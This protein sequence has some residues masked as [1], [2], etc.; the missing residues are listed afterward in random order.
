VPALVE[1]RGALRGTTLV[2]ESDNELKDLQASHVTESRPSCLLGSQPAG[3]EVDSDIVKLDLD[4]QTLYARSRNVDE[5][6]WRFVLG[7]S[8]HDGERV[9]IVQYV[10]TFAVSLAAGT[11]D[12]DVNL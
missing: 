7:W 3:L 4:A 6:E 11:Q 9:A 8:K 1:V 10:R 5:A 2:P 12:G